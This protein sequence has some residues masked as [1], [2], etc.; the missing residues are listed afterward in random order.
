MKVGR[1]GRR[2]DH[3]NIM[4]AGKHRF[5]IGSWLGWLKIKHKSQMVPGDPG[6]RVDL[7]KL[8]RELE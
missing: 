3:E 5:F 2:N 1:A 7:C 6:C 8:T 4:R